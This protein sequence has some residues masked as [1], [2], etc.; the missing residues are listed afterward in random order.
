[1]RVFGGLLMMMS[2]QP[3]L[4]TFYGSPSIIH[5]HRVID[6]T[7]VGCWVDRRR[8]LFIMSKP[9]LDPSKFADAM[10]SMRDVVAAD[11]EVVS[12]RMPPGFYPELIEP[13][14]RS[15]VIMSGMDEKTGERSLR[16]FDGGWAHITDV[17]GRSIQAASLRAVSPHTAYLTDH[18]GVITVIDTDQKKAATVLRTNATTLDACPVGNGGMM[19]IG[20]IGGLLA[21]NLTS[22]RID[23]ACDGTITGVSEVDDDE[24]AVLSRDDRIGVI[25]DGS[26]MTW[27][28]CDLPL[29]PP[30]MSTKV[31]HVARIRD[32]PALL[33]RLREKWRTKTSMA[34]VVVSHRGEWTVRDGVITSF[35]KSMI[36]AWDLHQEFFRWMN[37]KQVHTMIRP[38]IKSTECMWTFGSDN[39]EFKTTV[40]DHARSYQAMTDWM[41]S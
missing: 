40:D 14:D 41:K 5:S 9:H 37:R 13:L 17:D 23:R 30:F 27:C 6:Q 26:R 25:Q 4:R 31:F 28:G 10:D 39:T 24:I 12:T 15:S 20:G 35:G 38:T 21:I 16:I 1:M 32:S 22:G 11:P 8:D 33:L 2:P 36:E 3:F 34:I 29:D 7:F 18:S 19:T